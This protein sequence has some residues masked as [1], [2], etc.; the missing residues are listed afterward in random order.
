MFIDGRVVGNTSLSNARLRFNSAAAV[1]SDSVEGL[2]MS[3]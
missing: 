3:H 1:I 2:G